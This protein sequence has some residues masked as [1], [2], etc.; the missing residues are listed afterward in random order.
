[1][2]S[3]KLLPKL[4][5]HYVNSLSV[6]RAIHCSCRPF[7]FLQVNAS[8]NSLVHHYRR[9]SDGRSDDEDSKPGSKEIAGSGLSNYEIFDES[10]ST[11]I[12]D[13]DEERRIMEQNPEY[14]QEMLRKEKPDRFFGMNLKRE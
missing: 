4:F 5:S 6:S 12:L 7:H 8:S 13:I 2:N 14:M 10:K 1:M 3:S 9:Y 11:E